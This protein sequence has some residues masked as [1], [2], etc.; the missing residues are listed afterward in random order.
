MA[1]WI[2][3]ELMLPT[4]FRKSL[5]AERSLTPNAASSQTSL[6]KDTP[7]LSSPRRAEGEGELRRK[8]SEQEMSAAEALSA[9]AG[10][11]ASVRDD[12]RSRNVPPS[13]EREPEATSPEPSAMEDVVSPKAMPPKYE[14]EDFVSP[15]SAAV[16]ALPQESPKKRKKAV[17]AEDKATT[18]PARKRKAS[19]TGDGP[20]EPT[21]NGKPRKR[22]VKEKPNGEPAPPSEPTPKAYDPKRISAPASILRPLSQDELAYIRNPRNIKNPLKT[23]RPTKFG[24]EH[25][26]RDPH[27]SAPSNGRRPSETVTPVEEVIERGGDPRGGVKRRAREDSADGAADRAGGAKRERLD[28]A[29][30]GDTKREED[31]RMTRPKAPGTFG[32]GKEVAEHCRFSYGHCVP[33]LTFILQ[34]TSEATRASIIARIPPSSVS[35]R[36]TTG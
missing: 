35:G 14:P 1:V 22:A 21:G 17:K 19:T 20:V 13:M 31:D 26:P 32:K 12:E 24:S 23:G 10:A 9:L 3:P 8:A 25:S 30:R 18:A 28:D 6:A 4:G 15:K 16:K 34:I 11:G 29:P 7:Q 5:T 2:V 27:S 33:P 36:A